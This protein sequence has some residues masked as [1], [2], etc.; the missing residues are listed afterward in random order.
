MRL[1]SWNSS[2]AFP[3]KTVDSDRLL[4]WAIRHNSQVG[5]AGG[6]VEDSLSED[7]SIVGH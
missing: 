5:G 2:L 6:N 7:W 4:V 1:F 3:N